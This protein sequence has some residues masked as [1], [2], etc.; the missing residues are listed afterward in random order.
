MLRIFKKKDQAS[1]SDEALVHLFLHSRDGAALGVLFE[2]YMPL[3]YGICL[4]YLKSPAQAEDAVMQIFEVVNRKL[5]ESDVRQFKSWVST[6]ARNHCLMQLRKDKQMPIDHID[7]AEAW[8][9]EVGGHEF[10]SVHERETELR[11]LER[12]ME[13]LVEAQRIKV[14]MFYYEDKSYQEISQATGEELGTI[15]SHI[16]NGRR[17]LRN[18]MENTNFNPK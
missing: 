10:G 6:V 4:K 5:A 1:Q 8:Q 3:L 17:N 14:H 13:Q 11:Q 16:Q 12:C 7:P 15:R 2:R 18:C 9:F